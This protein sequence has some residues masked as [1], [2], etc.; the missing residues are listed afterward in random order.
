MSL[1]GK[2][3]SEKKYSIETITHRL[4]FHVRVTFVTAP[5]IL[6]ESERIMVPSFEYLILTFHSSKAL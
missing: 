2:Q 6:R 5:K 3:K 4:L 1:W